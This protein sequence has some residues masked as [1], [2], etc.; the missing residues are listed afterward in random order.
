M[1]LDQD[2]TTGFLYM[3]GTTT[4]NELK[5]SGATKSVFI[6]L[7]DGLDYVWIKVIEDILIDTVEYM[8]AMGS[9]S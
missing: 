8:S 7:F 6:A 9:S 1:F 4:A 2:N 5:I 3:T